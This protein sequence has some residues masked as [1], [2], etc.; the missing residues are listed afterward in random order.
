MAYYTGDIPV[1]DIVIEPAR[2]G[3]AID[4][5]PFSEADSY[6]EWRTYGGEVLPAEFLLTFEGDDVVVEWPDSSPFPAGGVYTL[7]VFLG[8]TTGQVER[9]APL[10]VVAQ[11]E[12]GWHTIDSA[13]LEWV[14][15]APSDDRRLH[16]ILGLARDQVIAYAPT[17][18]DSAAIPNNYR[19]GQ[20]MQ[21]RNLYNAG[22]VD[23]SGGEGS[24]DFV[25]R[26]FPL[27]W[28]VKQVLRPARVVGSIA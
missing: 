3:E 21:A 20:L 13:R 23:P 16:Q 26:P 10:Y 19:E 9:L 25:L 11:Q 5:T 4:L 1:E 28:M 14:S 7:T 27:D 22:M 15:G 12:D 8:T 6:V 18:T 24:G 2:D 17:L